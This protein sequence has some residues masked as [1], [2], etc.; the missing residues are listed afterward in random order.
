MALSVFTGKPR[1]AATRH[2]PAHIVSGRLL[3]TSGLTARDEAG[4]VVG[5]GDMRAQ[6]AQ[7]IANLRDVLAAGGADFERL[8]K[9]VIYVTDIDEYLLHADLIAPLYAARPSSTL[10]EIQRLQL[11]EMVVEI[12]AIAELDT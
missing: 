5:P 12:E 10:V 11:P 8:V 3:I 2:A 6:I 1:E 7:V 4:Q 9:L